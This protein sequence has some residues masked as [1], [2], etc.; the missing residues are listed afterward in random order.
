MTLTIHLALDPDMLDALV[1]RIASR[2]IAALQPSM[3]EIRRMSASVN[4]LDA[5]LAEL[6]AKVAADTDAVSSAEKAFAGFPA[7]I[8]AAVADAVAKGATPE[9]L[10]A[11]RA[12]SDAIAA[13][14]A[15]LA[16]A[17]AANTPAAPPTTAAGTA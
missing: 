16:A 15:G 3:Q 12:A 14:T 1:G 8:E 11:V 9:Q 4:T 7:L 13:N 17:V 5:E 2:V 10:A 6:T